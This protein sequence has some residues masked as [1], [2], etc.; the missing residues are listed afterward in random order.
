MPAAEFKGDPNKAAWLPNEAIAKI[1]MEYVRNGTVTDPRAPTAPVNVRANADANHDNEITSEAEP[2]ILNGLGG[3]LLL[4][5]ERGL[6]LPPTQPPEPV[7]GRPL[8]HSLS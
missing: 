5:D 7:Y 3:F 8:C 1:W 4:R 6:A 2:S